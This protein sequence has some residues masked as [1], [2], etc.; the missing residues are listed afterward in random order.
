[1]KQINTLMN[2]YKILIQ[3]S[4]RSRNRTLPTFPKVPLN[5]LPNHIR[6]HPSKSKCHPN[7]Y[8]NHF[9]ASLYGFI[10]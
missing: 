8:S 7:L 5:T 10:T 1:M 9:L 3:L 4:L 2:Y 6:L